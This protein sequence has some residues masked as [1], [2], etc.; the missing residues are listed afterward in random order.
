[1][2]QGRTLISL[3]AERQDLDHF[4][5]KIW[6]CS[7]EMSRSLV[8][9]IPL[10]ARNA[11][12]RVYDRSLTYGTSSVEKAREKRVYCRFFDDRDYEGQDA[13]FGLDSKLAELVN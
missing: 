2:S 3:V 13:V 1:M 7:F 10:V 4:R 9:E 11:F 12:G 8:R 5:P 6:I